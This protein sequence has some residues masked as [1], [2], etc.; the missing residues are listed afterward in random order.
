[1]VT[2]LNGRILKNQELR[3]PSGMID[4]SELAHGIYLL[5]VNCSDKLFT[6]KLI[7]Y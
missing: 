6:Q 5:K 7:K 2:D 3:N 1:M 4:I